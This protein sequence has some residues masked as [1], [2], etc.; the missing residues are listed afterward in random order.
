MLHGELLH[1]SAQA[2]ALWDVQPCLSRP[3]PWSLATIFLT[4]FSHPDPADAA[5]LSHGQQ[6]GRGLRALLQ[7]L[8][9][10]A[11]GCAFPLFKSR[12]P[13]TP[14]HRCNGRSSL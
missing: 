14:E 3:L 11:W 4:P 1:S 7:P 9:G 8:P 2:S 5:A 10:I 13:C 6:S 12:A